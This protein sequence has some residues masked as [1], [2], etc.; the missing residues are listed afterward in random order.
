MGGAGV[1]EVE[2]ERTLPPPSICSRYGKRNV[3]S[4]PG[5]L[6]PSELC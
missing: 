2:R 1:A 3:V 6:E 4:T 5:K